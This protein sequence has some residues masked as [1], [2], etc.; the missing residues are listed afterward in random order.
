M[1]KLE[2]GYLRQDV[3]REA[4][5]G[6]GKEIK[7]SNPSI[8]NLTINDLN[9]INSIL[10]IIEAK[11]RIMHAFD[12]LDDIFLNGPIL[13]E[14]IISSNFNIFRLT[15]TFSPNPTPIPFNEL[16]SWGS[17]LQKEG[18]LN[19]RCQ[20]SLLVDRFLC[21][22]IAKSM[23]VFEKLTLSD[24][25]AHLRRIFCMYIPFTASYLAWELGFETWI[26]KDGV[27]SAFITKNS[28]YSCDERLISNC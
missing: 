19:T 17:S 5:E 16:K 28:K 2:V 15:G 4:M 22:S 9:L 11:K 23:P 13:F 26:R 14:E 3:C 12:D 7:L 24:Q 25:I 10:P 8:V 18:L 20:K 21:F 6:K 27:M 1:K